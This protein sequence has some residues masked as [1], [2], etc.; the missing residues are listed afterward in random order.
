MAK[1]FHWGFAI[2]FTYGIAKQVDNIGQLEDF[3][4]LRFEVIFAVGWLV[5]LALRY[6]YMSKIETLSCQTTHLSF[7]KLQ[8]K[9]FT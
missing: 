8:L 6:V 9:W 3:A 7:K 1:V 4:L 5:L 2:A